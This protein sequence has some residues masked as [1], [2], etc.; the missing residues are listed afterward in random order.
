MLLLLR[1][2]LLATIWLFLHNCYDFALPSEFDSTFA[3]SKVPTK[4]N[5]PQS[6]ALLMI[7]TNLC[8]NCWRQLLRFAQ[9]TGA[10]MGMHEVGRQS[11]FHLPASLADEPTGILPG[12]AGVATE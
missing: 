1:R 11:T 5:R 8:G 2:I 3:L 12:S 9:N 10:R 6:D 7:A 4:D